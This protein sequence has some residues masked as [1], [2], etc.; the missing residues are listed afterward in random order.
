MLNPTKGHLKLAFHLLRYLK[1]TPGKGLLFSRSSGFD[2]S[3]FADSNWAKCLMSRKS[4]TGFRVFLVNCLVSWKSKKYTNVY[5]S[6]A[7]LRLNTCI[8]VL[9][10]VKQ[11]G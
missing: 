10:H 6:S 11:F 9:L 5:M 7:E 1:S 2:L 3:T 8:C 4:M